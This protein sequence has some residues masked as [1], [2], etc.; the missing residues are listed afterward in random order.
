M[1]RTIFFDF[2]NVIAHF[3]HQRAVNRFVEHTSHSALELTLAIYG[4]GAESMY[5]KGLINTYSFFMAA[6]EVGKLTC[7][8]EEFRAA[9][10]DIFT[11]NEPVISFIP[12]LRPQYR[13]VL[14]SN[15]ND[16]HFQHF[17][18]EY[19]DVLSHF[20]H[21]VLSH[22]VYARKPHAKFY[23]AAQEYAQADVDECLFIDD[24]PENVQAA[25]QHGWQG[26]VYRDFDDLR[27]QLREVGVAWNS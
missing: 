5:E 3:D 19:G 1:I 12:T 8:H 15:T 10:V 23:A 9:F 4:G 14:A 27:A 22:K 13:L 16:A 7:T 21:L 2:G 17:R 11:P 6:I 20:D 26:I 25:I 24:K 18:E